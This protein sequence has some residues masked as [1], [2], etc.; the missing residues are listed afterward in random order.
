MALKLVRIC[1]ASDAHVPRSA[2]VWVSMHVL[3]QLSLE[4]SQ[5]AVQGN[6]LGYVQCSCVR[7]MCMWSATLGYLLRAAG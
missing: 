3:G 5:A 7:H 2:Q 4:Q 6:V 1:V